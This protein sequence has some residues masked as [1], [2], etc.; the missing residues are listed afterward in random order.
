M[1]EVVYVATVLQN[2]G[3]HADGIEV[4]GIA[5]SLMAY[6][7]TEIGAGMQIRSK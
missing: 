3:V 1:R 2:E 7:L 6:F 5:L 4:F